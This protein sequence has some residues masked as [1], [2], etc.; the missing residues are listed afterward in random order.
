M[1]IPFVGPCRRHAPRP[2][3]GWPTHRLLSFP[4]SFPC[5][6]PSGECGAHMAPC[7]AFSPTPAT[8][9]MKRESKRG[10][11][12][13]SPNDEEYKWGELLGICKM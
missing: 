11:P 9:R 10:L 12:L 6:G 1:D 4:F 7:F 3:A 5:P 13:L 8:A 2:I